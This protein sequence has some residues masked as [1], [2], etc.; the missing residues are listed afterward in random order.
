LRTAL[1]LLLLGPVLYC[2]CFEVLKTKIKL[3][4]I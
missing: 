4:Y 2:I 1:E 3:N